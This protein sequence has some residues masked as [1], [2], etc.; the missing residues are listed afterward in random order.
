MERMIFD[1]LHD[2][3]LCTSSADSF[4]RQLALIGLDNPTLP[5]MILDEYLAQKYGSSEL[6]TNG[7]G[8]EPS[9]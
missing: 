1:A 3:A 5:S 4:S 2:P 6:T 7:T 8:P 9:E